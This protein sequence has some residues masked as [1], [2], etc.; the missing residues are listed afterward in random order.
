[1]SWVVFVH[2]GED[3]GD[4]SRECV[5]VCATHEDAVALKRLVQA[6]LDGRPRDPE[7]PRKLH[8]RW[9]GYSYGGLAHTY[10]WPFRPDG[11]VPDEAQRE[12]SLVDTFE[13]P[14]WP[15]HDRA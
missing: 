5:A 7:N 11:L 9:A 13:L 12:G 1:M 2:N 14:D 6:W 8:P 3:W 4:Q 10:R 15:A